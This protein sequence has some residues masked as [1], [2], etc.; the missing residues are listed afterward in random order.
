MFIYDK[1]NPIVES[2]IT[3]LRFNI[4][5]IYVIHEQSGLLEAC[6]AYNPEV[7]ESK[8]RSANIFISYSFSQSLSHILLMIFKGSL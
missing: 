2:Y 5:S 6:W 4:I 1:E 8:P 3:K 7:R